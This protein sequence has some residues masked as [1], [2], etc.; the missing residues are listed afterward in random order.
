MN[1]LQESL[2]EIPA[3]S[4]EEFYKRG[5]VAL[6][7]I[8]EQPAYRVGKDSDACNLAELLAVII[9]G[10][11][12]IETAE[13]LLA[14]FSSI[15]RIAQADVNELDQIPGV[16]NQAALRLKASLALGRRL[17]QPET[18]H[19]KITSPADA[20]EILMPILAHREQEYLMAMLLNT[21][22]Q[23]LDVVEIYH[24]SLNSSMVRVGEVFRPAL[25]RNA[26]ALIVSHNHPSNDPCP[27]PEDIQLTRSLVE[28]GKLMD[29]A[30]LDHLVIGLS[31]W[32][33]L[34]EKGLGFS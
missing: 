21:R 8:C 33:S 29:V 12:Q 6:L 3:S 14:Q 19:P 31:K 23:V 28:A 17:L 27:S 7:P 20:A 10:Q 26:A 4:K 34:K 11:D 2:F 16:S 22:N 5:K 25:Q 18:E 15:Q 9:G 24:G 32:V 1:Q 30:I 13:R